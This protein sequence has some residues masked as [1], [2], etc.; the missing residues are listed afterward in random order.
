[1]TYDRPVPLALII[2]GVFF[3]VFAL[4]LAFT[5]FGEVSGVLGV[6]C[7]A[8]G[9]VMISRRDPGPKPR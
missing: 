7:I 3:V 1:M 6:L 9:T 2:A 8:V 4:L 5:I